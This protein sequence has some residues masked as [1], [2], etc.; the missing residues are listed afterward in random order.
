[1]KEKADTTIHLR[2]PNE[3]KEE[4]KK[5]FGYNLSKTTKETF[6]K[7]I[8]RKNKERKCICFICKEPKS[9]SEVYLG[10]LEDG[11]TKLNHVIV[12]KDCYNQY[13]DTVEKAREFSL[14]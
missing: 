12:C 7:M 8:D 4:L 13:M 2:V 1:M 10:F 11:E 14:K 3:L 9:F 5:Q 6:L